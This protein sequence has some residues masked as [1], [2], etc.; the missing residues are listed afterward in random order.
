MKVFL[1]CGTNLGQG[2]T[3][4]D[5]K[6]NLIGQDDWKIYCF[7]PNPDIQ[8]TTLF[9]KANNIEYIQKAVWIENTQ[10][11]FRMQGKSMNDL[12]GLGSKLEVVDKKYNPDNCKFKLQ[13]V[14]AFDLS[15]FITDLIRADSNVE[16]YVKMDI[17]G[18]EFEVLQHLIEKD[19]I[20]YI[21]EI[22]CECHGRFRFPLEKQN[23][24]IIKQQIKDIEH[25]L[26]HDVEKHK[27]KF[28]FWI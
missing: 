23:H 21:K 11:E 15:E 28:H 22:F 26:K 16:I 9:P 17:E 12:K 14:D 8:L 24:P 6:M 1:D 3:E 10:L 7:E 27:V 5:K 20:K 4:F 25:K 19:T 2:L 13:Q 18:A